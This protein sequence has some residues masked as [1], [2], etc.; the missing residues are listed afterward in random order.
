MNALTEELGD[1]FEAVMRQLERSS[2]SDTRAVVLR[3][4]GERAFSAGGSLPWL[5]ER[6]TRPPEEN[7]ATMRAFYGRFLS[8]RRLPV[9]VISGV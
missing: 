3:G 6:T 7:T 9:P 2:A 8:V 5:H 4:A 1:E